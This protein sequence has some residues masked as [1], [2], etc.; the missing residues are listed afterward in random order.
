[1]NRIDTSIKLQ[2]LPRTGYNHIDTGFD[3][4]P[5]PTNF[6]V[7]RPVPSPIDRKILSSTSGAEAQSNQAT[8]PEFDIWTVASAYSIDSYLRTA[9][10][11]YINLVSKEG[12]VV[13]GNNK[14]AID[15][16]KLRLRLLKITCGVSFEQ[17]LRDIEYCTILFANAFLVRV[18]FKGANPLPGMK[19]DTKGKTTGGLFPVHPGLMQPYIDDVGK[20]I[21]W[22]FVVAGEDRAI[23]KPEDIIHVAFNKPTNTLFGIPFFIPVLEDIRTYRQL[24]WLT[25]ALLNRYLHPLIHVRKGIDASGKIV[26]NVHPSDIS[27]L[28]TL[29][30]SMAPDGL[31]VTGPDVKVDV[32]GVE[33]Q[34]IRAEGYL[35]AWRKRI[36]A[37]LAVSDIAMGEGTAGTRSTADAITAEMHDMAKAIQMRIM[38]TVNSDV[39]YT[40]LLEG[41][42]DPINNEDEAHIE[43]NSIATDEDIK[44]KSQVINEWQNGLITETEARKALGRQELTDEER[45]YTFKSLYGTGA[46]NGTISSILQPQN[47]NGTKASPAGGVVKK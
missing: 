46:P 12:W 38:E 23:F 33:S 5:K 43:Y 36:F 10:D 8:T 31:L 21:E 2:A 26:S 28:D 35:E 29:I 17:V 25:V 34:A 15:Y 32:H 18:P 14:Q 41:G 40:L 22:R 24:E 11:K 6:A 7:Y 3:E 9:V 20:V 27:E 1:M 16:L 13:K 39:V 30:K 47:G 37:G 44:K 19:L 42:F 4:A 45:Q